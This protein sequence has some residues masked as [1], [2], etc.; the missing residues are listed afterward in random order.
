[1]AAFDT[2]AQCLIE[3]GNRK[4]YLCLRYKRDEGEAYLSSMHHSTFVVPPHNSQLPSFLTLVDSLEKFHF[5]RAFIEDGGKPS[6]AS[7][8]AMDKSEISM[9]KN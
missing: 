9:E 1:M 4:F 7:A 6:V 2:D 8:A 5:Y 3:S